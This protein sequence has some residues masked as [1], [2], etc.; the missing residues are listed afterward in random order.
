MYADWEARTLDGQPFEPH[1]AIFPILRDE[2]NGTNKLVGTG[3]FLTRLGHFVTAKHVIFDAID[4]DSMVQHSTLHALHFVRGAEALVRHITKVSFHPYAD[5]AVGKMDYHV[6]DA[7]GTPL[8]NAVPRFTTEAPR[9]ESRVVT[10]AYP[11]SSIRFS[12]GHGTFQVGFYEG[13]FLAERESAR[14]RVMV[15]WPH[16]ETTIPLLGRAS[17]GP[18]FDEHGRVFGINCVSGIGPSYLGRIREILALRVPDFPGSNNPEGPT[19]QEL[20]A[21]RQIIFDPPL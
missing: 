20:A 12:K 9:I 11:Q 15:S 21:R 13:A 19:V 14:D 6:N 1:T 18:A 4:P 2:C 16:F 5:V 17:G 10:Y 7:D 3:F 8:L